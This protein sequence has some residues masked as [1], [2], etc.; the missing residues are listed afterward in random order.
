[1][2]T[3]D[4]IDLIDEL[5]NKQKDYDFVILTSFCFDPY[6]FDNFLLQKILSNNQTAKI[7]VLIDGVQYIKSLERF[8]NQTGRRYQLIPIFLKQG[9]FHPK[10]FTFISK[11]KMTVFVGSS[12]ITLPGFTRNAELITKIEYSI[13]Y[14]DSNLGAITGFY[15]KLIEYGFIKGKKAIKMI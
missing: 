15:E 10:L 12:N 7:I 4:A 6:F 13:D 5:S 14:S 11:Q 1:M 2:A 3:D 8:T 9:V